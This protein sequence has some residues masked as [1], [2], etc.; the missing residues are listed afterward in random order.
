MTFL[1]IFWFGSWQITWANS[2]SSRLFLVS[3]TTNWCVEIHL[4]TWLHDYLLRYN[5][6]KYFTVIRNNVAVEFLQSFQT[7]DNFSFV[8]LL[9]Q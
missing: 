2:Q 4:E 9:L 1:I 5:I 8:S 7:S 6:S 3:L